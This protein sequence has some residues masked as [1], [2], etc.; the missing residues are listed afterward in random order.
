MIVA[1]IFGTILAIGTKQGQHNLV[2]PPSDFVMQDTEKDKK[3]KEGPGSWNSPESCLKTQRCRCPGQQCF[4]KNKYW[5]VCMESCDPKKPEV[6]KNGKKT[7]WQCKQ[8]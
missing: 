4:A 6:D 1:A 5:A 3:V 8:L 7:F 2:R